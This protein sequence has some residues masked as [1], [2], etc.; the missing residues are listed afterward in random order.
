MKAGHDARRSAITIVSSAVYEA[1]QSSPEPLQT[2]SL[3]PTN[4]CAVPSHS[5][6]LCGFSRCKHREPFL[7]P[8]RHPSLRKCDSLALPDRFATIEKPESLDHSCVRHYLPALKE[9]SGRIQPVSLIGR[10]YQRCS[11]LVG[12]L[13][14]QAS[15]AWSSLSY[16]RKAI[17]C[18]CSIITQK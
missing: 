12:S 10:R 11:H 6:I 13:N 14:G 3:Y 9:P 15:Y 1:P 16:R 4:K 2:S 17:A 5:L 7:R 8:Y 18:T